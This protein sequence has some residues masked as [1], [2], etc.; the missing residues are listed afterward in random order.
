MTGPTFAAPATAP[1]TSVGGVAPKPPTRS[2]P[3][4]KPDE[5]GLR[6][7]TYLRLHWLMIV[8]CGTLIGTGGAFLAWEL[9]ASKYES[10]ALLQVSSA[11]AALANQ[12]NPQQ[13]KT[14][15]VTY[16]KTT[17]ALIKSEFVLNAALR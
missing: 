7:L 10:Y 9:L 17:S 12:N 13:A 14:E 2:K 5:N 8:F 16:L 4:D 11:P 6:V 1:A 3:G 15:F